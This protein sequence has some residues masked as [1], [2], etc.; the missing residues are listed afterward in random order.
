MFAKNRTNPEL[1]QLSI[2]ASHDEWD[3]LIEVCEDFADDG[4]RLAD[5]WRGVLHEVLKLHNETAS[6]DTRELQR[7]ESSTTDTSGE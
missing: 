3:A 7:E 4:D 5:A 1:V 6:R 2:I